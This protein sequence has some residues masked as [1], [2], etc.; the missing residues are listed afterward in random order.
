MVD[1]TGLNYGDN[2]SIIHRTCSIPLLSPEAFSNREWK[3]L[4]SS[5]TRLA[6]AQN[7]NY[8][9][10]GDDGDGHS[11]LSQQQT[12]KLTTLINRTILQRSAWQV[13]SVLIVVFSFVLAI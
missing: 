11:G 13:P 6:G 12:M 4:V 7:C 2:A 9:A 3:P 1:N 5:C 10:R 8:H